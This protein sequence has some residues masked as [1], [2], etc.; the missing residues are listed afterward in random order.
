MNDRPIIVLYNLVAFP[1]FSTNL[2]GAHLTYNGSLTVA[3][4]KFK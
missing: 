4:A 2:T 3:N 1:A